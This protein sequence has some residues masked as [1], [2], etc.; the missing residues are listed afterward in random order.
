MEFERPLHNR[1]TVNAAARQ[2]LER[3]KAATDQAREIV[4]NWRNSHFFPHDRFRGTLRRKAANVDAKAVVSE[5]RKRLKSILKKLRDEPVMRF[6]QMQ[7]IAGCR[8][9]VGSVQSVY[10]L[11]KAYQRSQLKHEFKSRK[12]YIAEPKD[13]GYMS[14]ESRA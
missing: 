9:V 1:E 4:E 14:R 2:L 5:R 10:A 3:G 13:T 6:T 11:D 12:D 8:A 7:D